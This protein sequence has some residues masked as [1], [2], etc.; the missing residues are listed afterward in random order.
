[1]NLVSATVDDG[2]PMEGHLG[3]ESRSTVAGGLNPAVCA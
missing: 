2:E 3:A 1:M